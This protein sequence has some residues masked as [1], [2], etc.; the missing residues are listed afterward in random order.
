[1]LS[2]RLIVFIYSGLRI[3][4][5]L[6]HKAIVLVDDLLI[7]AINAV[8]LSIYVANILFSRGV[9]RPIYAI[10]LLVVAPDGIIVP[11]LLLSEPSVVL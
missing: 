8:D 11:L 2:D 3:L 4:V 5:A 9:V 7:M 1:V 6:T 10:N